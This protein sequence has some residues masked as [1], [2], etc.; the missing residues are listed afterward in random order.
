MKEGTKHV[1]FPFSITH[2]DSVIDNCGIYAF[3]YND[4][5]IY[6]GQAKSQSIQKR[7][8][9]HYRES[10]NPTLNLWIDAYRKS[11]QFCFLEV[12]AKNKIDFLEKKFI[13]RLQPRCNIYN[14]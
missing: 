10:H 9:Q 8:R 3:W 12:K 6:I 11:L 1:L 7:L 5:C 14:R 2:I 13:R 4:K